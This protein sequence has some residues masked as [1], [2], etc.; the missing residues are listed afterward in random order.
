MNKRLYIEMLSLIPGMTKVRPAVDNEVPNHHCISVTYCEGGHNYFHGGMNAQGVR[1][2]FKNVSSYD[3]FMQSY[4]MGEGIAFTP[5]T[6]T[7]YN[8]KKVQAVADAIRPEI[9]AL[10]ALW[11]TKDYTGIQ[12]K[13]AELTKAI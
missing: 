7:R 10:C 6:I 9:E 4:M 1:V 11:R 8:A 5:V 13:L 3:G 12:T 2:S